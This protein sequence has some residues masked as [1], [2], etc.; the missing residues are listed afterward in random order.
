VTLRSALLSLAV[1]C[2]PSINGCTAELTEIVIVV[3][4][5][6]EVGTQL[7]Q[8]TI[9]ARGFGD[10][11][12]VSTPLADQRLPITLGLVHDGGPL[13][14]IT[15]V[16]SGKLA[17]R[18]VVVAK[19]TK[20]AF[21]RGQTLML[22]LDLL[23]VCG[24]CADDELTCRA[25][26]CGPTDVED[27]ELVPWRKPARLDAGDRSDAS[28]DSGGSDAGQDD[29]GLDAAMPLDAAVDAAVSV[30]AAVPD[31]ACPASVCDA[32]GPT[33]AISFPFTPGNFSPAMITTDPSTLPIVTI[34]C[35]E[36][37]YDTQA[38]RADTW[39]P[40]QPLP[41]VVEVDNPLA[42]KPLALAFQYLRIAPGS[43]LRLIGQRP[44]IVVVF[45]DA[46][47]DGTID[48]SAVGTTAGAGGNVL[49]NAPELGR[50]GAA[51]SLVTNGAT[52]GGGGG[53]GSNG[54]GGGVATVAGMPSAGGAA[55]T[56][57]D[58]VPLRGGCPGG[59]GGNGFNNAVRAVPGA[60]G[61]AVQLSVAGDLHLRGVIAASGGGGRKATPPDSG[62]GADGSN[63]GG[64][65]GSGG[66]ILVEA[67]VLHVT[68]DAWLTAN[69][70]GGGAGLAQSVMVDLAAA[71]S[72]GNRQ[73]ASPAAGGAS[74]S[75]TPGLIP[76]GGSGGAGAAGAIPAADG[77][78]STVGLS[79]RGGGGGGGGGAG[80]IRINR[81]PGCSLS[82]NFSPPPAIALTTGVCP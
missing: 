58:L 65:G 8:V 46:W 66:A 21:V 41:L 75:M 60:G 76:A 52:G 30:D 13:A 61:G 6:Y 37:I 26:V 81:A 78:T 38:M 27:G 39:C 16:V 44:A 4:T 22:R 33:A 32:G 20:V 1:V 67:G 11:R 2:V 72:D 19:R 40:N 50:D 82:G 31:A 34:D 55:S 5:D 57:T 71:G 79:G 69:G 10:E 56:D 35:G 25:G 29:A 59:R 49:C 54:G 12:L 23:S 45:G 70:G 3:D 24:V 17:G 15:V 68:R 77:A 64:G 7:D 62:V 42:P 36:V 63:G 51:A 53:L 74:G 48:V 47:I 14:P 18:D 43:T 73:N 28:N 80:R 9:Q